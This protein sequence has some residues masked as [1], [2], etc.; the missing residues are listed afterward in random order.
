VA[1]AQVLADDLR[2]RRAH[3]PVTTV[4]NGVEFDRFAASASAPRPHDLPP[5]ARPLIG[6][7]GALY[8]WIDWPL[9]AA[10]AR[11]MPEAE[12][13]FVGPVDGR[14]DPREAQA[15]PN[16][17]L[18]GPRAYRDVPDYMAHFDVCW[19]PFRHDAIAAA[20]NPV[21]LYEYLAL[22]KPT[23]STPVADLDTFDGLVH[24]ARSRE[25]MVERLRGA[26][27][28]REAAGAAARRVDFARRNSWD[29]RAAQL[30]AFVD[31]LH[32]GRIAARAA[33]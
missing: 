9:I 21:K 27:H 18:L 31:A 29:A 20:A 24:E 3:L 33:P 22:G 1:S 19:V 14:S 5:P 11:A 28:E 4:R 17:R 26:L 32:D 13:V 16:V 12:F 8:D 10:T 7:V 23:V 15:L 30:A 2:A 6:F 25:Q